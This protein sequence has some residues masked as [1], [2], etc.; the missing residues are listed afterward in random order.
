MRV[1]IIVESGTK[2]T[3]ERETAA[4]LTAKIISVFVEE[5]YGSSVEHTFVHH[6]SSLE[7][8]RLVHLFTLLLPFSLF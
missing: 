6:R 4:T 5:S 8:E 7:Q 2:C 1:A 3:R